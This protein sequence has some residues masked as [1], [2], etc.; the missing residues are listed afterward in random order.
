[1]KNTTARPR[2]FSSPLGPNLT[3][4]PTIAGF[5]TGGPLYAEAPEEASGVDPWCQ[6][7]AIGGSWRQLE[8]CSGVRRQDEVICI[9]EGRP[10]AKVDGGVHDENPRQLPWPAPHLLLAPMCVP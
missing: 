3:N 10:S 7:G 4:L 6:T 8:A 9:A 1:M 2:G 5:V